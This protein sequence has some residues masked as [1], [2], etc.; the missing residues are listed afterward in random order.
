MN[1]NNQETA[2]GDNQNNP[3]DI[4]VEVF[5]GSTLKRSAYTRI[6]FD[7]NDGTW[8][9]AARTDG[10]LIECYT[11]SERQHLADTLEKI[12]HAIRNEQGTQCTVKP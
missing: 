11:V 9:F 2:A 4:Q 8:N 12:V 1:D 3:E 6:E 5:L 10:L 7:V